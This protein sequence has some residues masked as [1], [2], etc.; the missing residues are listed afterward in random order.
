VFRSALGVG[1]LVFMGYLIYNIPWAWRTMS[2]S[3]KYLLGTYAAVPITLRLLG[4]PVEAAGTGA[5]IINSIIAVLRI[6]SLI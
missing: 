1:A 5:T 3:D 2:L 6:Y 4:A